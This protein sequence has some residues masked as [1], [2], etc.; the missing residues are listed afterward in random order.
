[1]L[2]IQRASRPDS[3]NKRWCDGRWE[4]GR[5]PS[6]RGPPAVKCCS[7]SKSIL[8]QV[9]ESQRGSGGEEGRMREE[10]RKRGGREGGRGRERGERE[11]RSA[12]GTAPLHAPSGSLD[13]RARPSAQILLVPRGP[14]G[15]TSSQSISLPPP[16]QSSLS[17]N[18][19]H[20]QVSHILHPRHNSRDPQIPPHLQPSGAHSY[21]CPRGTLSSSA[22]VHQPPQRL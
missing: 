22:G 7:V 4:A 16:P 5:T 12:H 8:M 19:C 20:Q 6:P 1:M 18:P 11:A 13:C 15:P 14:P 17:L 21:T 10:G 2:L 9:P 3:G